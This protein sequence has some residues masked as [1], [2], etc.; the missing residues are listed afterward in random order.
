VSGYGLT[1]ASGR[2]ASA[3]Q[4]GASF[5]PSADAGVSAWLRNTTTGDIASITDLLNTNP[6]SCTAG[7]QPNGAADGSMTFD[8]D[9]ILIPPIAANNGLVK[10]GIACWLELD[11]DT[12]SHYLLRYGP[13]T[14]N[15]SAAT[16]SLVVRITSAEAV[17]VRIYNDA[18]GTSART[19]ATPGGVITT[20]PKFITIEIDLAAAE[21]NKVV[22]TVDGTSQAMTPSDAVGTPGAFPAAMQGAPSDIIFGN[23]RS[24]LS[25]L[26][27]I[28][29]VGRNLFWT[30]TKMSGATTGLWT[31]TARANLRAFEPMT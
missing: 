24:N 13:G 29:R 15:D 23:R 21:A 20:G 28:G 6:G 1:L 11:N 17:D 16:D 19:T 10:L 31:P 26:P 7:R 27:F 22:V 14:A 5:S 30:V 25:T 9:A 3:G 12:V 2:Y 18:L 8:A 4:Y